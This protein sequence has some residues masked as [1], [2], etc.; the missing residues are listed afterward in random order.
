[1]KRS[2]RVNVEFSRDDIPLTKK[3]IREIEKAIKAALEGL[4][5][6]DSPLMTVSITSAVVEVE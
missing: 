4:T 5:V 6:V 2:I 1:M 3:T